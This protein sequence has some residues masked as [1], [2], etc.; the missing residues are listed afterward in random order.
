MGN[1]TKPILRRYLVKKIKKKASHHGEGL[2]KFYNWFKENVPERSPVS[3][4]EEVPR[5]VAGE[6]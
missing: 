5:Q 6:E 2:Q 4:F 1:I 3:S